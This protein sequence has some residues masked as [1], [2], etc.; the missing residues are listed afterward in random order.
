LKKK[1]DCQPYLVVC[2]VVDSNDLL[3][4]IHLGC[5][6]RDWLDIASSYEGVN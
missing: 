1:Y 6:L 3:D 2:A 5:F 4:A